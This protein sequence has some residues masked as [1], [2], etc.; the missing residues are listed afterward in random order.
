MKLSE[1]GKLWVTLGI[2][3]SCMVILIAFFATIS[4]TQQFSEVLV[5]VIVVTLVIGAMGT[6]IAIWEGGKD[7]D[8]EQSYSNPKRKRS[9][10]NRLERLEALLDD[11]AIVELE[12]LLKEREYRAI[13]Y[14]N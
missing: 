7:E 14:D 10:M 4:A 13:H 3:L 8:E 11:D 2:W 1:N 12:T 9:Q 5:G 6:T